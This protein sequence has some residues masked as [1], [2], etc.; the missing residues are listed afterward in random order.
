MPRM[1]VV[2]MIEPTMMPA[3]APVESFCFMEGWLEYLSDK[4][5]WSEKELLSGNSAFPRVKFCFS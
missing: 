1:K 2:T 3:R 4:M 5:D